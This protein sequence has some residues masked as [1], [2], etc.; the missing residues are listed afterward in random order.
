LYL[1]FQLGLSPFNSFLILSRR[2]D[3]QDN[4]TRQSDTLPN[5]VFLGSAVAANILLSIV[6]SFRVTL[7]NVTQLIVVLLNV[8]ALFSPFHPLP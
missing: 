8:K 6:I 1:R 3:I 7:Q 5:V 2:H 4:D